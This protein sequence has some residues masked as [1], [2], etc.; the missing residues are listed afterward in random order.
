MKDETKLQLKLPMC[1]KY[2]FHDF[3]METYLFSDLFSDN[4]ESGTALNSLAF[5]GMTLSITMLAAF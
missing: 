1:M 2:R 5:Q 4:F 3:L